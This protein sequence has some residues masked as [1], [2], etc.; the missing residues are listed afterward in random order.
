MKNNRLMFLKGVPSLPPASLGYQHFTERPLYFYH[1]LLFHVPATENEHGLFDVAEDALDTTRT[2][3]HPR[4]GHNYYNGRD[5]EGTARRM[6]WIEEMMTREV[7]WETGY[8]DKLAKYESKLARKIGSSS[9]GSSNSTVNE[10]TSIATLRSRSE[11]TWGSHGGSG[12][13]T[14]TESC[15]STSSAKSSPI[16]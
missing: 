12:T 11:D 9:S 10:Q 14:S 6:Q 5:M 16:N 13:L 8:K 2:W 4:G 15:V 3:E 1:G 7:D